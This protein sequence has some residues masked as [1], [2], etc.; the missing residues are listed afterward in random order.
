MYETHKHT[1]NFLVNLDRKPDHPIVNS[2]TRLV[3]FL[4]MEFW[5]PY[6]DFK[7][8]TR[9]D[10][11]FTIT[12]PTES[13]ANRV[14]DDGP[15]NIA[16]DYL[17]IHKWPLHLTFEEILAYWVQMHGVSLEDFS[18]ENVHIFGNPFME[19]I[20]VDDPLAC[21]DGVHDFL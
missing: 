13:V 9:T 5:A 12:V 19:V 11:T 15:S 16:G 17:A 8:S 14:L 7:V 4:I 21:L 2:G 6:G 18:F 1:N 10:I 20:V 3:G